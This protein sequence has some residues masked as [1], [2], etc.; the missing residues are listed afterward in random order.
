[1]PPKKKKA[2]DEGPPLTE[3]EKLVLA[4][5]EAMRVRRASPR[6]S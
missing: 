3:E 4:Q 6:R 2:K 1:M 5:A